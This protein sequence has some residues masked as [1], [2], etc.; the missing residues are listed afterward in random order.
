MNQ[1]AEHKVILILKLEARIGDE[2]LLK[3]LILTNNFV[4]NKLF[5]SLDQAFELNIHYYFSPYLLQREN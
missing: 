2:S 3:L 4:L 1:K 5:M